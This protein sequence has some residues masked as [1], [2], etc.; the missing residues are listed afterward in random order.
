MV[1][2]ALFGRLLGHIARPAPPAI[3]IS[4]S[5]PSLPV[6]TTKAWTGTTPRHPHYT[7]FAVPCIS[8]HS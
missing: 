5:R 2:R 4:A 1:G 6:S 3:L 7:D 8:S